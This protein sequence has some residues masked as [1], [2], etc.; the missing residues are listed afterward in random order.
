M[1]SISS[2]IAFI[3]LSF[4]G[5]KE[6]LS[7]FLAHFPPVGAPWKF[8]P[9]NA[10]M[11]TG[12]FDGY[13][14]LFG[15]GWISNFPRLDQLHPHLDQ[16]HL[17]RSHL[18]RDYVHSRL[19]Q[20]HCSFTF[21]FKR[22][23]KETTSN[24]SPENKEKTEAN[25][26]FAGNSRSASPEPSSGDQKNY[27]PDWGRFGISLRTTGREFTPKLPGKEFHETTS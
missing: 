3:H 23:Q 7:H 26:C 1:D 17:S 9:F 13:Y 19:E 8:S 11:T 25:H 24:L 16:N 4:E 18:E 21:S 6:P 5:R 22:N 12:F 27:E 10:K 15:I 2:S 14:V 20:D